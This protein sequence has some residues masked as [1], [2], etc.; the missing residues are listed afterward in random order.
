[1][2]IGDIFKAKENAFLQ[3]KVAELEALLTPEMRDFQVVQ[4]KLEAAKRELE[5][6]SEII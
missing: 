2:G 1:M 6:Q 4:R 5:Y 3:E